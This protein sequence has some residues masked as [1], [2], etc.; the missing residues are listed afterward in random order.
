MAMRGV[1]RDIDK[2]ELL[3]YNIK[4]PIHFDKKRGV[5]FAEYLEKRFLEG[6]GRGAQTRI[7]HARPCHNRTAVG[8]DHHGSS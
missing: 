7:R 4:I 3:K 6:D 5:F 8:A 2:Y 1:V